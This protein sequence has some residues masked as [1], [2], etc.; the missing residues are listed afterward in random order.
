MKPPRLYYIP[1]ILRT[2]DGHGAYVRAC[3]EHYF[4]CAADLSRYLETGTTWEEPEAQ[5]RAII[6]LVAEIEVEPSTSTSAGSFCFTDVDEYAQH[7]SRLTHNI[8]ACRAVL[9]THA[10]ALKLRAKIDAVISARS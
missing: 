9:K 1:R 4:L 8:R 5:R 7:R 3:G 2:F 6:L 10:S